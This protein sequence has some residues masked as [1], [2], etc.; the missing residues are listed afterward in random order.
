MKIET[1]RF[2][3]LL[4]TDKYGQIQGTYD[5]ENRTWKGDIDFWKVTAAVV[6]GL[7]LTYGLIVFPALAVWGG[8]SYKLVCV[9]TFLNCVL[10]KY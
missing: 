8:V 6:A 3:F 2:S 5:H 4:K 1:G 7:F 9:T 10:A